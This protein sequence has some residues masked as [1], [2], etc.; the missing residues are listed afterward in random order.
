MVDYVVLGEGREGLPEDA[1]ITE[2]FIGHVLERH[3]QETR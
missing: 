1:E 3:R 2:R